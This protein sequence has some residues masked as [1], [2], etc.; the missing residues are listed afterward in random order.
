[1]DGARD[2]ENIWEAKDADGTLFIQHMVNAAVSSAP[3]EISYIEYPWF[4]EGQPQPQMKLAAVTYFE[5]TDW[6]IGAGT[7]YADFED[8]VVAV[9]QRLDFNLLVM[10]VIAVVVG[11]LM[12]VVLTIAARARG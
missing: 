1:M 5:P 6:V 10:V 2:G 4:N 11:L 8:T 9:G 12:T 3:G 7:Y